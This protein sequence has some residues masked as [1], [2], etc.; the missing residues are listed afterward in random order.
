MDAEVFGDLSQPDTGITIQRDFDYVVAELLRKGGWAFGASFQTSSQLA[1]SNVTLSMQQALVLHVLIVR[2]AF[3]NMRY[4]PDL[5][6]RNCRLLQL[7][8]TCH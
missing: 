3:S 4:A 6:R 8:I 7:W 1:R 5:F 2:F